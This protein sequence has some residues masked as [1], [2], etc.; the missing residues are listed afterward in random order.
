MDG[1]GRC[2]D[3]SMVMDSRV[4]WQGTVQGQLDGK[5]QS[6]GYVMTMDNED[7]AS[8]TAMSKWPTM[9]ATKANARSRH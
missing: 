1:D 9:E 6:I 2:D 4:Q 5:G 7:S 8:A 3:K